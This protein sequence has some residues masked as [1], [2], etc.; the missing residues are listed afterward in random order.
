MF[1]RWMVRSD[2]AGVDFGRWK[3]LSPSHLLMPLDTHV[4]QVAKDWAY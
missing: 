2:T 4:Y 1:L 3:K